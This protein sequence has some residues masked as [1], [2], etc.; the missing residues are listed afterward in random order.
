MFPRFALFLAIV[1][2]GLLA[3]GCQIAQP[4]APSRHYVLGTADDGG[5]TE[6]DKSGPTVVIEEVR[7]PE[8]LNRRELA[9]RRSGNKIDY[10]SLDLWA[11]PLT[12][13]VA[14]ALRIALEQEMP[15]ALLVRGPGMMNPKDLRLSVHFDRFEV[16]ESGKATIL[17]RYTILRNG[18][19]QHGIFFN[20]VAVSGAATSDEVAA[21]SAL[22]EQFAGHLSERIER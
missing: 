17:A 7:I 2:G 21:L 1:T 22:L 16:H 13:G 8:Y 12:A 9:I 4:S 18:Q 11:E 5:S 20:S 15:E 19:A 3:G 6:L 10:R 14:R